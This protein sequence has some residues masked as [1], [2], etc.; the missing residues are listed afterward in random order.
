MGLAAALLASAGARAQGAWREFTSPA[1]RFRVSMPGSPQHKQMDVRVPEGSAVQHLYTVVEGGTV[2][3]ASYADYPLAY[4]VRL[5]AQGVIDTDRNDFLK[6]MKAGLDS[7]R[8]MTIGGNPGRE[9]RFSSPDGVRGVC[10]AY[11]VGSR[12][13]M[14]CSASRSSGA[15]RQMDAFQDSFRLL[16]SRF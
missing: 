13:Y 7:E 9:F 11:L 12:I 2:Y 10:S 3:I 15:A 4:V 5:G 8:R 1:G 16:R 6:S 14:L